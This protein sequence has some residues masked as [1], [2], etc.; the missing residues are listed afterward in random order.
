MGINSDTKGSWAEINMA[1]NMVGSEQVNLAA[2]FNLLPTIFD[3]VQSLQKA[4]DSQE[5]TRKVE[6]Q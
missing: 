3:I 2:E 4:S 5:M 1:G 6:T